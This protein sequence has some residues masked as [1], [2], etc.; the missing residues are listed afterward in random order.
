ML[1]HLTSYNSLVVLAG[2][3]TLGTAAGAVGAFAL[4][5][6]RA[7]M[8]DVLAHATLPGI[9]G[10]FLIAAALGHN[11]RSLPILLIGAA[12]AGVVGV[13]LTHFLTNATRLT[14]DTAMGVV[15]GS[16]F[17][18]GAV[19]LSI[20]QQL[21]IPNKAGLNHFLLG[22]AA[23]MS[24]REA[25]LL[26]ML[27]GAALLTLA[28]LY[29]EL[30]LVCFDHR[31]ARA[32][33]WRTWII[34]AALMA[35]IVTVTVAGLQAVGIVLIVALLVV[36]PATARLWSDRLHIVLPL[37]ALLG[38][39]AAATGTAASAS[40]QRLPT[41]AA[42][43]IAAGIAFAAS[44]LIAP[45]R[46]LLASLARRAA[47]AYR[48]SRDHTL[49]TAYEIAEA[50]GHALTAT[51]PLDQALIARHTGAG[52][53]RA[54][55]L[56]AIMRHRH[57]TTRDPAT[58]ALHLTDKGLALAK[59]VTRAHRLIEHYLVHY[60]D[61]DTAHAHTPADLIEHSLSEDAIERLEAALAE[62]GRV[63]PGRSVHPIEHGTPTSAAPVA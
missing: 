36:P 38:G 8:G 15:L 28:L 40:T 19:L 41:G 43:V 34:D 17:G 44:L 33:G 60:A 37:S 25:T 56:L 9:A 29:K 47:L 61:L 63:A 21:P 4:L 54:T 22:Q 6:K 27:A 53:L 20:T 50:S 5:R 14:N 3:T 24:A 57:Y 10:A 55:A 12:V 18:L 26:A 42:I 7:L 39:A 51:T 48:I 59:R 35:L 23:A 49:R 58:A 2:V 32:Q 46:G 45:R 16:M 62:A 31:F 52:T 11:P 1:E 13:I 30:R